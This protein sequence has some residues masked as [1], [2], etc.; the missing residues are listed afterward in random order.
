MMLPEIGELSRLESFPISIF[1]TSRD[2]WV[3]EDAEGEQV[4][5]RR[6]TKMLWINA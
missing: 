2:L 3:E 1:S 6:T 5:G 4:H